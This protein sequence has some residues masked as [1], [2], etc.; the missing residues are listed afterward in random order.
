M[1]GSCFVGDSTAGQLVVGFCAGD[2]S[3]GVGAGSAMVTETGASFVDTWIL[4]W[5]QRGSLILTA[6]H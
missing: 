2:G 6:T 5:R 4:N 3:A 1:A